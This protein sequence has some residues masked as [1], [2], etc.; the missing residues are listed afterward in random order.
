MQIIKTIILSCIFI[1]ICHA[2]IVY[3]TQLLTPPLFQDITGV[4]DKYKKMIDEM[5]IQLTHR[6]NEIA[7]LKEK[8]TIDMEQELKQY[9]QSSVTS[10]GALPQLPTLIEIK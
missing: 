8:V 3:V 6:D 9:V 10:I 1:C 2:L 4:A 5:T 7:L